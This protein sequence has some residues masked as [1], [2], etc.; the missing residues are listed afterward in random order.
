MKTTDLTVGT[1]YACRIWKYTQPHPVRLLSVALWRHVAALREHA[2]RFELDPTV[3]RP[4]AFVGML[5]VRHTD[6]RLIRAEDAAALAELPDVD[7]TAPA[8]YQDTLTELP[9]R[10]ATYRSCLPEGMQLAVVNNRNLTRTWAEWQAMREQ[11]AADVAA[12]ITGHDEGLVTAALHRPVPEGERLRTA[13]AT[14]S[15]ITGARFPAGG[16]DR[17]GP[18]VRLDADTAETVAAYLT[19]RA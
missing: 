4:T 16:S 15:R 17:Q 11:A 3:R 12:R 6:T 5:V 14:I 13:V 8:S 7:L 10:V 19:E 9:E 18:Y 1:V 2:E